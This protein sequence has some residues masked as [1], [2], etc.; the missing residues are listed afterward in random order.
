MLWKLLMLDVQVFF[1]I[2]AEVETHQFFKWSDLLL[3]WTATWI[4]S[5]SIGV[6]CHTAV[7]WYSFKETFRSFRFNHLGAFTLWADGHFL[8]ISH[9]KNL[10]VWIPALVAIIVNFWHHF[11]PYIFPEKC[12]W[13]LYTALSM[14]NVYS[15]VILGSRHFRA[16]SAYSRIFR[17][18]CIRLALSRTEISAAFPKATIKE[19]TQNFARRASWKW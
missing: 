19:K 16:E 12:F 11:P 18:I 9:H 6:F 7:I 4:S 14:T 8:F 13:L 2:P 1:V 3:W 10:C 15:P 5:R 17:Q